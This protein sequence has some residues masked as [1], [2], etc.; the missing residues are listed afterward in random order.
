MLRFFLDKAEYGGLGTILMIGLFL[1]CLVEE[2]RVFLNKAIVRIFLLVCLVLFVSYAIVYVR[3]GEVLYQVKPILRYLSYF[4]VFGFVYIKGVGDRFLYALFSFMVF[5]QVPVIFFQ[6]FRLGLDRPYGTLLNNNH[7]MYLLALYFVGSFYLYD[8]KI[9][10]VMAFVL[11]L[12]MQGIGGIL[13]VLTT[14]I[15][16]QVFIV[17]RSVFFRIVFLII[18]FAGAFVA[19]ED[20]IYDILY[21]FQAFD[22]YA[23]IDA[24]DP[25]GAGSVIWRFVTWSLFVE[26][27]I[28]KNGVFLGLGMDAASNASP[29][30]VNLGTLQDPHNDYVR[31]FTDFGL[32]GLCLYVFL[33][34][35]LGW[36]NLISYYRSFDERYLFLFMVV[37]MLTISHFV[38]NTFPQSTLMW[39][40]FGFFASFYKQKLV[41]E[42]PI[43][44]YCYVTHAK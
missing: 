6:Y 30:Y 11:S 12:F 34:M 1:L 9:V 24:G 7:L 27:V 20:R 16:Y 22:V 35:R 21:K 8:K 25:S 26:Y 33:L 42:N 13:C 10:A 17:K 14:F 18:M 29:Y 38:A 3:Y 39:F 31:L 36:K 37:I 28:M 19:L 44:S 40:V 23:K 4:A 15:I 2:R 32:I 5:F 41:E 43:K